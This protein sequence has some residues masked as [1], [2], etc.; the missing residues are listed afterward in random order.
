MEQT[1]EQIHAAALEWLRDGHCPE[2]LKMANGALHNQDAQ[3]IGE[4]IQANH[5]GVWSVQTLNATVKALSSKLHWR[6]KAQVAYDTAYAKLT[7]EQAGTFGSWWQSSDAKHSIVR[8][9]DL[10]FE[11]GS[12]IL[13]WMAGKEFSQSGFNL[14]VSNLVGT[15][16]LHLAAMRPQGE[17]RGHIDDGKGFM[18]REETNISAAERARRDRERNEQNRPTG[19]APAE[20]PDAWSRVILGLLADG[21]HGQQR[22]SKELYTRLLAEG[23]SPRQISTELS[24]LQRSYQRLFSPTAV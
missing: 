20:A 4:H 17:K 12:K 9:G 24:K 16:G 8:D 2:E 13:S 6:S 23:M 11:N 10:G 3:L 7:P 18:S 5:D 14:A 1:A 22:A 15:V 19:T 21:T